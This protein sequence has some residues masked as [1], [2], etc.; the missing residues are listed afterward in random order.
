MCE[1]GSS[2]PHSSCHSADPIKA[3]GFHQSRGCGPFSKDDGLNR[4]PLL[5]SLRGFGSM[6]FFLI[7]VVG[8]LFVCDIKDKDDEESFCIH[9][10]HRVEILDTNPEKM[11]QTQRCKL[12]L[13]RE[14]GQVI[15]PFQVKIRRIIQGARNQVWPPNSSGLVS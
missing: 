5:S 10:S 1:E 8:Q 6:I 3:E 14:A 4:Q 7:S 2:R 12:Q 13:Q 9:A 15:Y 11:Q